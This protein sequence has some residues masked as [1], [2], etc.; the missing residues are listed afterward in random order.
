MMV[1]TATTTAPV[2]AIMSPSSAPSPLPESDSAMMTLPRKV[3]MIPAHPKGGIFS[4]NTISMIRATKNT[5]V[6]TNTTEEAIL[7]YRRDSKYSEK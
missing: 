4:L 2:R 1:Y 5:S 6:S 3:A 7:V